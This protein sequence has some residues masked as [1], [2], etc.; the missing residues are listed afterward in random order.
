MKLKI[1]SLLALAMTLPSYAEVT[2]ASVFGTDMVLQRRE[3][4]TVWGTADRNE[5][6]QLTFNDQTLRTKADRNGH[7]SLTL[8]P[9]EAG[10]PYTMTIQGK[11]NIV[12]FENIL[13]GEVWL[14]SGQS[15]MEWTP[16][17]GLN[18]LQQEIAAADYPQIRCLTVEK[19]ISAD[20]QQ[21]FAGKWEICT[22]ATMPHFSAVGYFFARTLWQTMKIPIGLVHASWGGTDIETWT[23]AES[24]EALKDKVA[25]RPYN[26][27]VKQVLR[28][29]ANVTGARRQEAYL[30][31][32]N[33]DPALAAQ[34][35]DTP[36]NL[37][38]WQ[39]MSVPQE[40]ITTPLGMSDGHVWFRYELDLPD[41]AA[42]QAAT[43]ALG[44]IDDNDITW[45]N[46]VEVGRTNGH[47]YLRNYKLPAGV[48][49]KGR[50]TITVRITDLGGGGGFWSSPEDMFLKI[51]EKSYSLAGTW[52]YK[53]S[54]IN[55][56]YGIVAR[57]PN[58]YYATLYNAMIN[59]LV[60]FRIKGVIWYQGENNAWNA[61]SYRTLFPNLIRNWRE[62]W[63]YEFPFYWVQ[64][65]N[66]MAEDA[67]PAESQWA[68]LREA[69]TMTLD[70]PHTGQAVIID[71]GDPNDIHPRNKQDVGLRLA[72]LA[73]HNDYGYT[74][75]ICSAP[76]FTSARFIDGRAEISFD[77]P[78]SELVVK[79]KYGYIRGF[80]VAG[81]DRVF[82]WAKA[83]IEH[84][85]ILVRSEAVAHPVAVRYAWA[86]NPQSNLFSAQSLPV[87]PFRTDDW[88]GITQ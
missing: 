18:N 54:V 22:P 53:G 47:T 28:E 78:A 24:Y 60:G 56:D 37:A 84:G 14:C 35:F 48:L 15:N 87:R 74:E 36:D 4:V 30:A 88:P 49:K 55:T 46:G 45:V 27:A 33:Q 79:D 10:G 67:Q 77:V 59:P 25:A 13:I 63:G 75:T 17:Q 32:F 70:L 31:D 65:A 8:E 3:P 71:I 23:S 42:D 9:M 50:N 81:E 43:L 61:R 7:W 76:L 64:L 41:D 69:Q 72:L 2:P 21:R 62:K 66:Y 86:N 29:M 68:E 58:V 19:N 38:Q 57:D 44:M 1:L 16:A 26:P 52:R 39:T 20:P 73:L 40:W 82:H 12:Q 51:G 80:A 85:K 34:W 11:D 6:V 83:W 5:K